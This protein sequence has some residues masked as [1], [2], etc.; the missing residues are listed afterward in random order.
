MCVDASLLNQQRLGS[1]YIIYLRRC[2]CCEQQTKDAHFSLFPGQ[3][4][5][6]HRHKAIIRLSQ[7]I[8]VDTAGNILIRLYV[9]V[10]QGLSK[11]DGR[12]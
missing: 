4:H 3:Q 11:L 1:I 6:I 12:T 5:L 7:V 9:K 8:Y 10:I 2:F